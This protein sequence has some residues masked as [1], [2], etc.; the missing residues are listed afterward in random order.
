MNK[1]LVKPYL[2][3]HTNITKNIPPK[4]T[5]LVYRK[6]VSCVYMTAN[7]ANEGFQIRTIYVK[8]IP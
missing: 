8:K 3:G 2:T 5:L 6:K 1:I 7:R 4:Q